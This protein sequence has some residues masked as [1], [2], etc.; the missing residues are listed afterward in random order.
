MNA[1]FKLPIYADFH[2][3][4]P[5]G[6]IRLNTIGTL[7]DLA[8]HNLKFTH[9]QS[10]QLYTDDGDSEKGLMISGTVEFSESESIWVAA[11][12]WSQLIR[13]PIA[14]AREA[15]PAPRAV[16]SSVPSFA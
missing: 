2:N 6:R 7:E 16:D 11:V 4:D 9:G 1:S 12:D 13:T 15:P 14:G 10:I 3:V 8:R 5:E